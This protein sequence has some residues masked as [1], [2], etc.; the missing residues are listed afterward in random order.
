MS[1]SRLQIERLAGLVAITVLLLAGCGTASTPDPGLVELPDNGPGASGTASTPDPGPVEI[2]DNG[3][4][5]TRTVTIQVA[6]MSERLKL[7]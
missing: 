6:D 1:L 7:L 4:G 3:S 5:A 2:P